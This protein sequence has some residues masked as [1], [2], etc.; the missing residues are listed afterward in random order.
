M[1]GA[2][3]NNSKGHTPPVKRPP[4]TVNRLKSETRSATD[5]NHWT[6]ADNRTQPQEATIQSGNNSF[7]QLFDHVSSKVF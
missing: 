4:D 6:T 1:G 3:Q 2:H 5:Q 7:E